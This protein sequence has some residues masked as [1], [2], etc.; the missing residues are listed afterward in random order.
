MFRWGFT[1]DPMWSEFSRIQRNFDELARRMSGPVGF[2]LE[3]AWRTS[4]I[5]P[6]LN[7]VKEG[8]SFIVTAEVPGMNQEDLEIKVEGDTL[9]LKG[10]RK[11][12]HLGDGVSYHRRERASGSFQRSLTLPARV[13][14]GEVKARYADGV[15]TITLPTEKAALPEQI[16]VTTG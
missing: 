5:F 11:A 7:V 2:P 9:N 3:P 4:P 12:E 10:E 6:A 15:L 16:A 13:E 8:S 14:A 1:R